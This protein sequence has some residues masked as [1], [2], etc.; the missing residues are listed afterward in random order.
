MSDK[1]AY[2][3]IYRGGSGE[4]VEKKSRFIGEAAQVTDE[5]QAA[6]FVEGIRKKYYDARH[7][8]FAYVI[9]AD[10][11]LMR[12]A[13]DGEPQGT[14]GKPMLE[15]LT[16][17]GLA[18]T[19]VVVT[20]YFGG[21]LLGTGGL[22]RCYTAAAQAAL[23]NSLIIEKKPGTRGVVRADYAEIGKLQYLFNELQIPVLDTL[24]EA[25]VVFDLIVPPDQ[26][27]RL[28]KQLAE[29]SAGRI[30]VEESG[31]VWYAEA[32]GKIMIG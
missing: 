13:D 2:F 15:V 23:D 6:A 11:K 12:A 32:E 9:G 26:I 24:Y 20:R 29:A 18:N 4:V 10:G 16:G 7:H 30:A 8:C 5:E 28:N 14:A 25:S 3:T 21:T 27:G 31:E 22:V 1:N 19:I 17:R